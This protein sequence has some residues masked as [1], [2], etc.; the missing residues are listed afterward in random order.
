MVVGVTCRVTTLIT[1]ATSFDI[2]DGATADKFG[3]NVAVAL[4][5][6][7]NLANGTATTPTIYPTSTD[8]VLTANGG[9]FTAGEVRLTVFY[10]KLTAPTS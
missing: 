4:G 2:G 8:I 7:S 6:T 9:N 5:T 3:N 1:G 10:I